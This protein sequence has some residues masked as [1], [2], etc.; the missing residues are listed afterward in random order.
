MPVQ[1]GIELAPAPGTGGGAALC[2]AVPGAAIT[3]TPSKETRRRDFITESIARDETEVLGFPVNLALRSR[4]PH[5]LKALRAGVRHAKVAFERHIA[6]VALA[7]A[8]GTD[9]GRSGVQGGHAQQTS[10]LWTRDRSGAEGM[11]RDAGLTI[12]RGMPAKQSE[13]QV[14]SRRGHVLEGHMRRD[15]SIRSSSQQS[16]TSVAAA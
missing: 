6:T 14:G 10:R 16:W 8:G 7:F 3:D 11:S 13:I 1:N 15:G 5:E 9:G 4:H 2:V 12:P